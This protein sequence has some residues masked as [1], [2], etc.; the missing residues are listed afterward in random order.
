MCLRT[1]AFFLAL[2]LMCSLS[3]FAHHVG[4]NAHFVEHAASV[5]IRILHGGLDLTHRQ[6]ISPVFRVPLSL[7]RYP[8]QIMLF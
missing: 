6:E 2:Y 8:S 5:L 4:V 3:F 7:H 1:A